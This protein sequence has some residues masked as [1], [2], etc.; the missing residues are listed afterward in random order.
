MPVHH[1]HNHFSKFSFLTQEAVAD[2]VQPLNIQPALD[3]FEDVL[4]KRAM[5]SRKEEE[6]KARTDFVK[7]FEEKNKGDIQ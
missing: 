7:L 4:G 3:S 5:E 2:V 6:S 1:S